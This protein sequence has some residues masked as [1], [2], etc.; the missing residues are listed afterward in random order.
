[1]DDLRLRRRVE[2]LFSGLDLE[3][4]LA[5]EGGA[6]PPARRS[7]QPA[8]RREWDQRQT[9]TCQALIEQA[10]GALFVCDLGGRQIYS[11]RA[12]Y[13]LLG[14]DYAEKEL[15]RRSFFHLW[16]T[17]S[18]VVLA[19]QVLAAGRESQWSGVVGQRRK[20]GSIFDA[21]LTIF[22]VLTEDGEACGIASIIRPLSEL[23][24]LE[25]VDAYDGAPDPALDP[26]AVQGP[27]AGA[28]RP[29]RWDPRRI[30]LFL[31]LFVLGLA[32]GA[33]LTYWM[34]VFFM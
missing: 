12:C 3:G 30:L 25:D 10:G 21:H 13:Q 24:R 8:R 2:G 27:Q 1:M 14:Y 23:E 11:N 19:E 33:S 6:K 31:A 7:G 28:E 18:G 5:G 20:D 4:M 32:L 17:G 34:L 16:P 22:P 15:S 29:R 26:P 9:I